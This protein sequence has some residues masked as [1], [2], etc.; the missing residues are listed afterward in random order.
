MVS[1][2]VSINVEWYEGFRIDNYEAP[3]EVTTWNDFQ[4]FI[5]RVYSE[6]ERSS[7]TYNKVKFQCDWANGDF[8]IDRLDVGQ[9][10]DYNPTTSG[11]VGLYLKDQTSVMYKSSFEYETDN[12][13]RVSEGG[14]I[15]STTRDNVSWTDEESK[16]AEDNKTSI[17]AK[18]AE[19]PVLSALYH[20][21]SNLAEKLDL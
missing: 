8:M 16:E 12:G 2:L 15:T 9:S 20:E 11:P 10:P 1:K 13:K 5:N 6:N 19:Y 3:F 17:E 7:G 4:E 14:K 18:E 21:L